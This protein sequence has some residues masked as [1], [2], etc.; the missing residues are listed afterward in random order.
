NEKI[1]YIDKTGGIV[2]SPRFGMNF[3]FSRFSEGLASV[4]FDNRKYGFID[5]TGATVVPP[6]FDGSS[7][8]NNGV[9]FVQVAPESGPRS[10]AKSGIIDKTGKYIWEPTK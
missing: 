9:A 7:P 1:G 4:Q 3:L 10:G 2:I 8:F 6:Q 5:K